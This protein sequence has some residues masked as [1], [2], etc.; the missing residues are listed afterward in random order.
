MKR[1]LALIL[2]LLLVFSTLLILAIS[3][4]S[5]TEQPRETVQQGFNEINNSIEKLNTDPFIEP[6][7]SLTT[8]PEGYIGIYTKSDLDN[9]RNDLAGN[10]ILMNDIEFSD[11]DFAEG[12]AFYNNSAGW[13]PIG[14]DYNSPFFG[15]FDGNGYA[16]KN[17]C[18]NINSESEE[19]CAGLFGY[20]EHTTIRNLGIEDGKV[21]VSAFSKPYAGAFAGYVSGG[22][23]ITNCYNTGSVTANSSNFNSVVGGVAGKVNESNIINCYNT[24]NLAATSKFFQ[25]YVG[26]IAGI[27]GYVN[28]NNCFNT[29]NVTANASSDTYAG[30]I[31][32]NL[33]YSSITNC[34]NMESVTATSSFSDDAFTYAGGIAGCAMNS[35]LSFCYNMK[36]VTASSSFSSPPLSPDARALA[37]AGGITGRLD[38]SGTISNCCNTGNV[39][40]T[41]SV[42]SNYFDAVFV[43]GI[44]GEFF[45]SSISNCYN[46]GWMTES[47]SNNLY[48]GGIMGSSSNGTITNCY[49]A[50]NMPSSAFSSS[51][52][53][54]SVCGIAGIVDMSEFTN[55]Y[56]LNTASKGVDDSTDTTTAL[57]EEQMK[58]QNC[59]VGFDFDEVWTFDK[60]GAC[61]YPILR[62]IFAPEVDDIEHDAR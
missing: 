12:G 58:M 55:C 37:R 56:Y 5:T 46:T 53:Y 52:S 15:T 57:T 44:S 1:Y 20:V 21:M 31:V 30:G 10:Y 18:V 51:D 60:T 13:T 29:G 39:K 14:V 40:G 48:V 38:E 33:S 61:P 4:T 11:A 3:Q 9:V 59:F 49:N 32:G 26:G 34:Y 23:H 17:L 28:I 50:G 24:G 43:G 22:S 45:N 2:A 36:N 62:E 27:G 42:D 35:M 6:I 7:V 25:C 8:V 19:I 47:S 16:I 54:V 41:S